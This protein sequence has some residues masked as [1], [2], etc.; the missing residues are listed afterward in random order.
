[1]PSGGRFVISDRVRRRISG[2]GQADVGG[3][4][5]GIS[6]LPRRLEIGRK[7][8][9]RDGRDSKMPSNRRAIHMDTDE[10]LTGLIGAE[11][12]LMVKS[13]PDLLLDCG[14][15][16]LQITVTKFAVH[17]GFHNC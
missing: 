9:P 2:R 10:I 12:S 13:R 6:C 17:I 15:L 7:D 14:S 3:N 11:P 16:T 1:M 8:K 5:S 4:I